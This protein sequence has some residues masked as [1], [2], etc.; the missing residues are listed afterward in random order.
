MTSNRLSGVGEGVVKSFECLIPV[1]CKVWR[2]NLIIT[3]RLFTMQTPL[4]SDNVK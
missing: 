2:V 4:P 1:R 3:V